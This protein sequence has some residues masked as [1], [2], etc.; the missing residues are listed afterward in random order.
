MKQMLHVV[1]NSETGETNEK[2]DW[3]QEYPGN[4]IEELTVVKD[5]VK[6][7]VPIKGSS[8]KLNNNFLEH[9]I[10]VENEV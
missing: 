7:V 9:K 8:E 6:P 3:L 1:Q 2:S 5:P 10:M 4:L